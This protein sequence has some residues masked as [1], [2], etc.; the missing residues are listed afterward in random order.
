MAL[1]A[2]RIACVVDFS[3]SGIVALTRALVLAKR[4]RAHLDVLHVSRARRGGPGDTDLQARLVTWVADTNVAHVPTSVFVL[5]GRAVS[6]IADH[7]GERPADLLVLGPAPRGTLYRLRGRF[8]AAVARRVA[9]PVLTLPTGTSADGTGAQ[10]RSIV[11]AVD[12]S[13]ASAGALPIAL[14][15]AQQSGGHLTVLHVTQRFPQDAVYSAASVP[16]LLREFDER[17][18]AIMHR[19][20]TLVPAEA[21]HWC[22]IDYRLVPGLAPDTI[23]SVA[24]T[25][26]ADLVVVGQPPRHWLGA[27]G[28]TVTSIL[29]QSAIPV[30]TVPGPAGLLPVVSRHDAVAAIDAYRPLIARRAGQEHGVQAG[31][32]VSLAAARESRLRRQTI[33][34]GGGVPAQPGATVTRTIA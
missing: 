24:A 11:C 23:V 22:K 10:F 19:L 12:G 4:R 32:V 29:A 21:T 17:G 28:S 6:A 25:Q 20:R 2:T 18:Q 15:L 30:L 1:S 34:T 27:L 13:A 5:H 33:G 31:A 7:V 9:C 3:A 8:A 16:C 14:H 26:A